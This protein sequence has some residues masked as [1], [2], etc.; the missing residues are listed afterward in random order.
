M[1]KKIGKIP[2]YVGEPIPTT[3]N[4]FFI[5]FLLAFLITFVVLY[6]RDKYLIKNGNSI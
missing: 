6:I 4:G 2:S 5:K 1:A 3:G